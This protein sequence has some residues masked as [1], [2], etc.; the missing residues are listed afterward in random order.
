VTPRFVGLVAPL[1]RADVDTDA[2]LP[3][4]YLR[5]IN[6]TGFG[7]FLFDNWRYLKTAEAVEKGTP[8]TLNPD[9]VLN[10][11]RYKGAEILLCRRNFGSGSSR[12]H[13][14]WALRDFGIRALI[15][16]SFGDTFYAN[17]LKNRLLP[18]VLT[19]LTIE[20]LFVKVAA[21]P[22]YTLEIDIEGQKVRKMDGQSLPFAIDAFRKRCLL[23]D[24]DDI[25]YA[26]SHEKLIRDFEN[27]R[28]LEA[29]WIFQDLKG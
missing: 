6:K 19:E 20:E 11:P 17:C 8:R 3:K 18:I 27:R 5:S 26:L 4:Q 7:E 23:D 9:F 28:R 2:I 25:S 24:L 10:Q 16:P 14:P 22:G 1:D 21:T 29:P 15:S 13:A 12:E